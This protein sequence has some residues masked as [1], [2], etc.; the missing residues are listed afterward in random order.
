MIHGIGMAP[1]SVVGYR[2]DVGLGLGV[3]PHGLSGSRARALARHGRFVPAE[4][5]LR[6]PPPSPGMSGQSGSSRLMIALMRSVP[7]TGRAVDMSGAA[8]SSDPWD[9]PARNGIASRPFLERTAVF[10]STPAEV[11][12]LATI[13]VAYTVG[14]SSH[15]RQRCR[16]IWSGDDPRLSPRSVGWDRQAP[17]YSSTCSHCRQAKEQNEMIRRE[18]A[19]RSAQSSN[20]P[21]E[22]T[23]AP[24]NHQTAHRCRRLDTR[25]HRPLAC[26][27]PSQLGN[28]TLRCE[29]RSRPAGRLGGPSDSS[30]NSSVAITSPA[31]SQADNPIIDRIGVWDAIINSLLTEEQHDGFIGVYGDGCGT[32]LPHRNRRTVMEAMTST[33]TATLSR[34]LFSTGFAMGDTAG[35]LWK[36]V[37]L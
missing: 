7:A 18:K 26:A 21:S 22:C 20:I 1:E 24:S 19:A 5:H 17:A 36:Q 13:A 30:Q 37:K 34:A 2:T 6:P 12:K 15:A 4:E 31:R 9:P 29:G 35:V 27:D 25:N 32:T 28:P 8:R 23:N 14:S 10:N 11:Q 16:G 3:P 33:D